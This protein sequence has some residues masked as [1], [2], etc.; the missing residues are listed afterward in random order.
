MSFEAWLSSPAGVPLL[1]AQFLWT[2]V[3]TLLLAMAVARSVPR[4]EEIRPGRILLFILSLLLAVPAGGLAVLRFPASG[5][6]TVAGV[7][8]AAFQP[9]AGLLCIALLLLSGALIGKI[10]ALAAGLVIGAVRSV[11]DT[12]SISTILEYGLTGW[13]IAECLGQEYSGRLFSILRRPWGA[14]LGGGAFLI[15]LRFGSELGSARGDWITLFDYSLARLPGLLPAVLLECLAGAVEVEGVRLLAGSAWPFPKSL[16]PTRYERSLAWKIS[17]WLIL[18]IALMAAALTAVVVIDMRSQ[19][20]L[21]LRQQVLGAVRTAQNDLPVAITIGHTLLEGMSSNLPAGSPDRATV[22]SFLRDRLSQPPFFEQ[23]AF[24]SPDGSA[25]AAYPPSTVPFCQSTEEAQGCSLALRGIAWEGWLRPDANGKTWIAFTQ[26]V[27]DS[28]GKLRG[29]LVGR[30]ALETNPLL[31]AIPAAFKSLTGGQGMFLDESNRVLYPTGT[32]PW[33]ADTPVERD[34]Q[35]GE[36]FLGTMP[37]GGTRLSYLLPLD[38]PNWKVAIRVPEALAFRAALETGL[39]VGILA[40]LM[41]LLVGLL[42]LVIAQQ[43]TSPLRQLAESAG[44]IA[45]GDLDRTV[46]VSG[47]DEMGRL[48]RSLESMRRNL[49]RQMRD[50]E[51]LLQAVQGMTSSLDLEQSM[52]ILLHSVRTATGAQGVRLVL[53]PAFRGLYPADRFSLGEEASAL[54]PIDER[55][56]SIVREA[57]G[58]G[59]QTPWT[60]NRNSGTDDG[61]LDPLPNTIGALIVLRIASASAFYGALCVVYRDPQAFE[62]G[63]LELLTG[64]ANQA[65]LAIT[66]ARLLDGT[67]Y[68]RERLAAILEAIPEGVL[69]VDAED[70]LQYTNPTAEA[71]LGAALLGVGRPVAE[72]LSQPE[73]V[74][75]L[76]ESAVQPR[77]MEFSGAE[78][79]RLRG[80]VRSVRS[81]DGAGVW[82]VCV[83]QDVTSFRE[84]D[85]LKTE[86]VHTV[87]HDLRRPLTMM[88]GLV[89]MIEML[90]P[91][92]PA[93]QEYAR[94]IRLSAQEMNRLVKDL[95]DLG[96]VE[97]G[98]EIRRVP[99]K[100]PAIVARVVDGMKSEAAANNI[101]LHVAIP[102]SLP[103]F[104]ADASLLERALGNLM[105]NAIRFN[106]P[107]GTVDLSAAL[108]GDS[109]VVAVKDN[110]IGIAPADQPRIFEKFFRVAPSSSPERPAWGLGLAIAKSV[111]EWHG[112]KIWFETKLGQGSTFYLA[113]PVKP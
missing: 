5:S 72:S 65:S 49:R 43:I 47:Q 20:R 41:T 96:R 80:V 87:S 36:W 9:A 42:A 75:F 54:G 34:S 90:G 101:K 22:E 2:A 58:G 67:E 28:Q 84:L 86:F 26:P 55:I 33:T 51:I 76:K 91:L 40:F 14:A 98:V 100:L 95:L 107:G 89:H 71:M 73:L 69:V 11:F 44:L 53:A 99:V 6:A 31:K 108:S 78:G 17:L 61:I 27:L 13:A 57:P 85:E 110:G 79:R 60:A 12:H 103:D 10:P 64:F 62:V 81:T 32:E 63:L 37:G 66:N 25:Y 45:A 106:R 105:E 1:P 102:E 68:E 70:C 50:Q 16:R 113:L 35:G 4:R 94:R 23:I 92:N 38:Y 111:A 21:T 48:G 19:A 83:I 3:L 18:P 24:L 109:V 39:H 97:S 56:L 52:E 46:A 82:Q 59:R 88:E 8:L 77:G 93:Q 104:S 74:R 29:A 7:P 112:G 30:T 15:A